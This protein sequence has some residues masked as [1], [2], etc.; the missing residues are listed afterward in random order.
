VEELIAAAKEDPMGVLKHTDAE[1]PNA[2]GTRH[3]AV[4][5]RAQAIAHRSLGDLDSSETSARQAIECATDGGYD[6]EAG[7]AWGTLGASLLYGGKTGQARQ[8]LDQGLSRVSGTDRLQL[9]SH[10]AGL[11]MRVGNTEVAIPALEQVAAQAEE[12]GSLELAADAHANCGNAH[13]YAGRYSQ[14]RARLKQARSYYVEL[15]HDTVAAQMT[16]NLGWVAG[17][18]GDFQ[19]ALDEYATAAPLLQGVDFWQDAVLLVDRAEAELNA[20]LF[21]DAARDAAEAAELYRTHNAHAEEAEALLILAQASLVS[22]DRDAAGEAAGA[23]A[24][25]FADQ[26]RPGWLA[27][28]Q[29]VLAQCDS[30]DADQLAVLSEDLAVAGQARPAM[31][32]RLLAA[33]GGRSEL[34]DGIEPSTLSVHHQLL[35]DRARAIRLRAAGNSDAA[36]ALLRSRLRTAGESSRAIGSVDVRAGSMAAM[37]DLREIAA[38]ICLERDDGAGLFEISE[39]ASLAAAQAPPPH[40]PLDSA[41]ADARARLRTLSAALRVAERE[42]QDSGELAD[43]VRRV[44]REVADQSRRV[45]NDS[46]ISGEPVTTVQVGEL[47]AGTPVV[48][49]MRV[50]QELVRLDI[51]PGVT[52]TSVHRL[53]S[54]D[55]F[56][57]QTL[58]L[59]ASAERALQPSKSERL[60]AMTQASLSSLATEL[61]TAL[62]HGRASEQLTVIPD[63]ALAG[64]PWGLLPSQAGISTMVLPMAGLVGGASQRQLG[65]V[66]TVAGPALAQAD[67]EAATVAQCYEH[68]TYLAS[69]AST[70]DVVL[71]AFA[72]AD[73][74]HIAAHGYLRPDQPMLS[75][76][77]LADGLLTL[78]DLQRVRPM[79]HVVVLASC[80]SARELSLDGDELFGAAAVLLSAGAGYVIACPISLPDDLDTTS[81]MTT[82]HK[83]LA[84]GDTPG[85]SL[86]YCTR[87]LTGQ[88]QQIARSMV[89]FGVA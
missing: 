34:L 30:I 52:E 45:R 80:S 23:A 61:D 59:R 68:G 69:T 36:L 26:Q 83:R 13:A 87:T 20:G 54:V 75:S 9:E 58:S 22:G 21:R 10:M 62:F 74:V 25:A 64:L 37:A 49:F 43:Q 14:A 56:R 44:E 86:T 71:D 82:L 72:D 35:Y 24:A 73:V 17:L 40:A 67:H 1:L 66:L 84:A 6:E 39:L 51:D 38:A 18:A 65:N 42:F 16:H 19:L 77:E 63:A 70:A 89:L 7:L 79:P 4:L 33:S 55:W 11:E 57:A 48:R 2:A 85:Q 78:A 50:G 28:S 76:I 41:F 27:E 12:I 60:N 5:L 32:A 46:L 3:E 31:T 47:V 29:V 53:G 88:R 81:V 8:A 15:G